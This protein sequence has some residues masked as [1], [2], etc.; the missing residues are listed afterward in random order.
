MFFEVGAGAIVGAVV[1]DSKKETS[2]AAHFFAFFTSP[3]LKAYFLFG[4]DE[5]SF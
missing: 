4:E 5:R 3:E 1:A 2:P